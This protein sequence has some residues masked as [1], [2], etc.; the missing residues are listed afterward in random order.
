MPLAAGTTKGGSND[1]GQMSKSDDTLKN[2]ALET[3]LAAIR[4]GWFVFPVHSSGKETAKKPFAGFKWQELSSNDEAVVRRWWSE[5]PDAM[6]AVD[7]G[8]S[9]LL[10]VD[11]D[12]S[13][14]GKKTPVGLRHFEKVCREFG[15]CDI[16]QTTM[17]TSPSGGCHFYFSTDYSTEE[18]LAVKNRAGWNFV[19]WKRDVEDGMDVRA[20]GGFIIAPGSERKDINAK[21][22]CDEREGVYIASPWLLKVLSHGTPSRRNTEQ[23]RRSEGRMA[24]KLP[25]DGDPRATKA[26]VEELENLRGAQES[27]RNITLNAVAYRLFR[28]VA[29]GYLSEPEVQRELLSASESIG[30]SPREAEGT[31]KSAREGAFRNPMSLP[32]LEPQRS[33]SDAMFE[34]YE[35]EAAA[36]SA[37]GDDFLDI[38]QPDAEPGVAVDETPKPAQEKAKDSPQTGQKREIDPRRIIKKRTTHEKRRE[39]TEWSRSPFLSEEGL[40][41]TIN[42][43]RRNKT[44]KITTGIARLDEMLRGGFDCFGLYVVGAM[45]AV[46]KSAFCQQIADHIALSRPVL[47]YTLEMSKLE[48]ITRT[49]TRVARHYAEYVDCPVNSGH[50]RKPLGQ[51]QIDAMLRENPDHPALGK[52]KAKMLDFASNVFYR[53]PKDFSSDQ[54]FPTVEDLIRDIDSFMSEQPED[55]PV[56]VVFIDYL[57]LLRNDSEYN[58]RDEN[59]KM[60][61]VSR[62]LKVL[63]EKC[64]V[65]T[66]S[67]ISRSSYFEA[68]S[69]GAFKSCGDI[70]YSAN[71]ALIISSAD[72]VYDGKND[73]ARNRAKWNEIKTQEEKLYSIDLVKSR[74]VAYASFCAMYCG[75]SYYYQELNEEQEER[76]KARRAMGVTSTTEVSSTKAR[77]SAPRTRTQKFMREA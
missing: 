17:V 55:A 74:G 56:P 60:R 3:A 31:I 44:V 4:R 67:S 16:P 48:L 71:A 73:T 59:Q 61:C 30:L 36:F 51:H 47:Y 1:G 45:S 76:E 2:P 27:S 5:H 26:M 33:A 23:N 62:A 75:R 7:C 13:K 64:P 37:S 19:E 77:T 42:L 41:E 12:V 72:F 21:Y 70:E 53:E 57:Q 18:A 58:N 11:C 14:D 10:V 69:L 66:I 29:G 68:P 39:R 8:K 9:N 22:V 65:V 20:N 49:Y 43:E 32:P 38:G 35:N 6:T 63:S 28:F 34:A 50:V 54:V 46:G 25:G 52:T 15:G 40:L 24:G